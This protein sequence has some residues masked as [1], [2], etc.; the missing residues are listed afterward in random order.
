MAIVIIKGDLI[1]FSIVSIDLQ[2]KP[3]EMIVADQVTI[4]EY[5]LQE[6]KVVYFSLDIGIDIENA[7]VT[8]Q[9][10]GETIPSSFQNGKNIFSISSF[11]LTQNSYVLIISAQSQTHASITKQVNI[12]IS[13]SDIL[14]DLNYENTGSP[15][16]FLLEFNVTSDGLPVAFAPVIIEID[17]TNEH[18][19]V[20]DKNGNYLYG[21]SLPLDSLSVNISCSV[22]RIYNIVSSRF[23]EISFENVQASVKR[24]TENAIVSS[25]I[26][27]TFEIQ[28]PIY[29]DRWILL[30]EDE[31][32]PVLDAYIETQ[33]LR[34][35]VYWD[36]NTLYWQ[37]QADNETTN[38]KLILTTIGPEIATTLEEVDKDI[39]IHF[40][41]SS[42][43][44]SYSNISI[45][46]YF[47][48]SYE[49]SKYI[50]QLL[51]NNQN[52]VTSY[53]NLD[54][55]DLYVF[56]TNLD[57][58]KGSLLILDLVG[59][60]VSNSKSI[61][62]V[63]IPLVSGSAVLFGAV[64]TILKIYNKKKGMILEI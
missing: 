19:G 10:D 62:N 16:D 26:T 37:T 35:P 1:G 42:D 41:I 18:T 63:I 39:Q 36:E 44:K 25:N 45:I 17:E 6:I 64:A 27:L 47:N 56:I 4:P 9:L 28:Y 43:V 24:S 34:I 46:Y 31:M 60:K 50:W 48:D 5:A 22:F 8:A 13:D 29:H 40:V 7:I 23:F 59:T 54:V 15:T 51:A 61:T 2:R 12:T 33:T 21:V 20:T 58:A 38:H 14:I 52:D 55:N 57:L 49:T 32:V 11:Y 53:Y 30:V 3:A